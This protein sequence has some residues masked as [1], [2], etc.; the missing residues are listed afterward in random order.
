MCSIP[1]EELK[2]NWGRGCSATIDATCCYLNPDNEKL[3]VSGAILKA[4]VMG[5]SVDFI[6][7]MDENYSS[8]ELLDA[9]T[10]EVIWSAVEEPE[11]LKEEL[12]PSKE[13]EVKA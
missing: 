9:H 4:S 7:F 11:R 1:Y 10:K 5:Y 8:K 13:D 12:I 3:S 2:A 6:D